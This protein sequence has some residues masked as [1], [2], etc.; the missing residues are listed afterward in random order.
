[1]NAVPL[2]PL[3]L[4]LFVACSGK[5]ASDADETHRDAAPVDSQ[6]APPPSC[7][8]I[9]RRFAE[10]CGFASVAASCVSDCESSQATFSSCPQERDVLWR[11]LGTTHVTCEGT[12][13]VIIDCSDER[14]AVEKCARP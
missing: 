10:L 1:M 8:T 7:A 2:L 5:L 9:C 11:C 12:Q 13:I 14:N 3:L 6:G 4:V